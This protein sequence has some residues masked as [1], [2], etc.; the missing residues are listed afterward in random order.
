M[1][2]L[3]FGD[4]I[5]RTRRGDSQSA[6][7]LVEKYEAAIRREIRFSILDQR[8]RRLIDESDVLQS[9]LG[10]FFFGLYSGQY[11]FDHPDKL[12]RLLKEMV[13]AKVADRA[14]YWTAAQRDHR[15]QVR[16]TDA[17]DGPSREPSP[18]RIVEDAELLLEFE[19]RLSDEER[20]I[21][22]LRRQGLQWPAVADAIGTGE[23]E[24]IRKRFDRALAR[25][26]KELGFEG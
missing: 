26:S 21:L 2:S 9:V 20:T 18:S 4:L 16:A 13:K 17:F 12:A 24:A 23:P 22:A 14:R 3:A 8:L 25:V 6:R 10:R 1:Q 15:R 7:L 11:A 5:D 19:K